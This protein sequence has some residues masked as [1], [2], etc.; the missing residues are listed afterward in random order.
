LGSKPSFRVK[1]AE[2][3][4]FGKAIASTF[5]LRDRF[6]MDADFKMLLV[7]SGLKVKLGNN[8]RRQPSKLRGLI[9]GRLSSD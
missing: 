4:H 8:V 9:I 5:N 1:A 2:F 6:F 3:S 7:H